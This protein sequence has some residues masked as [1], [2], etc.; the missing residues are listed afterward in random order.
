MTRAGIEPAA[1]GLKVRP[2][3]RLVAEDSGNTGTSPRPTGTTRNE[4]TGHEPKL[5]GFSVGPIRRA[6]KSSESGAYRSSRS[7]SNVADTPTTTCGIRQAS[8][9]F[10]NAQTHT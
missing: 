1:Y 9:S 3:N 2:A 8:N 10:N 4:S 6:E 7:A 5:V